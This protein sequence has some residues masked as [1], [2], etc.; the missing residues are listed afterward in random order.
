MSVH[1]RHIWAAEKLE[2]QPSDIIL[3]IGCGPGLTASLVARKLQCGELHL[4][5][6]SEKSILRALNNTKPYVDKGIVKSII[7]TFGEVDL[8]SAHY[9]KIYCFNVRLLM[10]DNPKELSLVKALIGKE[11][12]F[13]LFFQPP[14]HLPNEM[15]SESKRNLESNGFEV[16]Q[17]EIKQMSPGPSMCHVAIVATTV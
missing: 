15:A 3:E 7:G 10:E 9:D 1:K 14:Y 12:H 8:L 4:L 17:S 2:V 6:R 13:Y 11:G 16:V 5:D